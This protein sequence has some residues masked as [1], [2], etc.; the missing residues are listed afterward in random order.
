MPHRAPGLCFRSKEAQHR[1]AYNS[2]IGTTL[3]GLRSSTA[4]RL[5]SL[6]ES[7]GS[8][9]D[10]YSS[11]LICKIQ[12]LQRALRH[13]VTGHVMVCTQVMPSTGGLLH[14]MRLL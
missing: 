11:R 14:V 13:L 12:L 6:L 7:S 1:L 2:G 9:E 8:L 3:A 5:G 4:K 10:K